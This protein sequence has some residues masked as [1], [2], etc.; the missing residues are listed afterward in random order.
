[1]KIK[2]R[3]LRATLIIETDGREDIKIG[4]TLEFQIGDHQIVAMPISTEYRMSS[5]DRVIYKAEFR[6]GE[7][8]QLKSNPMKHEL[9]ETEVITPLPLEEKAMLVE[10]EDRAEKACVNY[11]ESFREFGTVLHEISE[12]KLY[13]GEFATFESYMRARWKL[14]GSRAYQIIDARTT[15][16]LLSNTLEIPSERAALG[17]SGLTDDEKLEAAKIV[18]E[19]GKP[20]TAKTVKAAALKVS[21]K[22]QEAERKRQEREDAKAKKRATQLAKKEAKEKAKRE[23]VEKKPAKKPEPKPSSNEKKIAALETRIEGMSKGNM[24][25][26]KLEGDLAA[27]KGGIEETKPAVDVIIQWLR[28]HRESLKAELPETIVKKIIALFA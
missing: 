10:L 1:M 20:V 14:S 13:R 28:D 27:L 24:M 26:R 4:Q 16:K 5:G 19:S 2:N 3:I 21:P 12:R 23:K 7:I 22:K 18:K 6:G 11:R 17:F 8:L 25:R 9:Q 15:D